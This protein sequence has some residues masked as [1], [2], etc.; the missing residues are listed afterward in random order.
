MTSEIPHIQESSASG[1]SLLDPN[2][3]YSQYKRIRYLLRQRVMLLK[4]YA[5]CIYPTWLL[6]H[7]EDKG[8][9]E[10]TEQSGMEQIKTERKRS[11]SK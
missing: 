9:V 2:K 1:H 4:F 5:A 7:E 11:G 3:K 6:L 8:T 10:N